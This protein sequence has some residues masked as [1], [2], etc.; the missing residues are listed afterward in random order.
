M[1]ENKILIQLRHLPNHLKWEVL[2]FVNF[3]L[4]KKG[5][6]LG[7]DAAEIK[8]SETTSPT[9]PYEIEDA[10]RIVKQGCDMSSFGNPT[11]YQRET[12]SDRSLPHR[13]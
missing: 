9:T 10:V 2:D 8:V 7:E 12:R 3:L 5:T 11:S 13:D 6:A 4:T 1:L